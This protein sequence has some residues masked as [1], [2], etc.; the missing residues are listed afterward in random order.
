ML[1]GVALVLVLGGILGWVARKT[2]AEQVVKS[3]C[4]DR[5]LVCET[6]VVRLGLDGAT[7]RDLKVGAGGDVPF[8]AAEVSAALGWAGLFSPEVTGIVVETPVVRGTLDAKG[9][10]FYGLENLAGSSG[11]GGSRFN[12]PPIDVT[13]GQVFLETEA[14]T[15]SAAISVNGTFPQK[16]ELHLAMTPA[17]LKGNG[18]E[19]SWSKGIV[20][21]T[22]D[23]GRIAGK[24]SLVLERADVDGLSI[25]DAKLDATI[26]ADAAGTGPMRLEWTSSVADALFP[27]GEVKQGHTDGTAT[28][29]EFPGM[30]IND[31]LAALRTGVFQVDAATF[32]MAGFGAAQLHMEA[33]LKGDAGNIGGPVTVA[34]ASASAPQGQSRALS[35]RGVASRTSEGGLLF[36]GPATASG[37]GLTPALRSALTAP[38]MFPGPLADHGIRLRGAVD[39]ALQDFSLTTEFSTGRKDGEITFTSRQTTELAAASG[40]HAT[41]TP[42]DDAPWL[43]IRGTDRHGGGTIVLGGGGAPDLVLELGSADLTDSGFRI[44]AEALRLKPWA[45]GGRTLSADLSTFG[46]ESGQGDLTVFGRGWMAL[47][48]MVSGFALDSTRLSGGIRAQ[49]HDGK[50]DVRPEATKCFDLSTQGFDFGSIR[51][52][53]LSTDVC[54]EGGVFVHDRT[55]AP[56]GAVRLGAFSL[57]FASGATSGTVDLANAIIDWSSNGGL[58]MTIRGDTL[59][60]PLDIGDRT[61][62]ISGKAPRMGVATGK[63]APKLSARLGATDFTGSLIPAHVSADSFQFDGTSGARSVSGSLSASGVLIRD[64]IEDP[65]YAPLTA[66]FSATLKDGHMT[67]TGPLSLKKDGYIVANTTL[68]LDIVALTGKAAIRSLPLQFRPGSLQPVMLSERLR[69]AFTYA[70]GEVTALADIDIDSGR[71]AGTG[72]VTV[73]DFG[74][75]TTRLGRVDGVNGHVRFSD[76]LGLTTDRAQVVTVGAMNIGV[77]L[78]DGRMVFH[79]DNGRVIGVES[80]TFPFAGGTIALAPLKWTLGGTNQ[81]VE[82]AAQAIDLSQLIAVLKL[83][84]VDATGT[85]SGRFPVDFEGSQVLVRDAR[86]SADKKGG[87]LAY[88]GGAVDA[89]AGSDSNA[90]LAFDALRDL[91]FSILEIGLTGDL[92]NRTVASVHLL[93]K[94]TRPLAF[95]DKLT[96][97]K[98]Q[99]FQFNF[100][101][102]SNLQELVNSTRYSSQQGQFVDVIVDLVNDQKKQESNA[103]GE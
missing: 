86:L 41:V 79:L 50:W 15:L 92:T 43:A 68:D 69:G 39:R 62:G 103:K 89:A 48:G 33:D 60:L 78:T 64:D 85:V 100:T 90:R 20:D 63:G 25:H 54:P 88:T 57:P 66:D 81:R 19:F 76:L 42:P 17:A 65:L 101:F 55:G 49:R 52:K 11:G 59:D 44:S 80:A 77:P 102:D 13:G 23:Q 58:A 2:I 32:S 21:M 84:D 4:A 31:V 97:P 1:I 99:A 47:S 67:M 29:T 18:S 87:H 12:M 36:S 73:A 3:W 28:F 37:V 34:A 83:P 16:G 8:R 46:L 72:E 74:F 24:A 5:G 14:G 10:R 71:L 51:V 7:L 22:A 91:D 75:Q 61:L 94:N 30:S 35:V 70:S 53:Q 95:G 40:L 6:T 45:A 93:G 9:V 38:I 27:G 96:M 26:D 82:V 98:G 56:S